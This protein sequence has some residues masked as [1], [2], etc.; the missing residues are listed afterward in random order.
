MTSERGGARAVLGDVG[1]RLARRT[2]R[3]VVRTESALQEHPVRWAAILAGVFAA[4]FF[5]L[6]TPTFD[7]NDD[8]GMMFIADGTFYGSPQPHLI[9]Q[10]PIVGIT[11]STLYRW[12]G[13]INW[14]SLWLYSLHA[15]ALVVLLALVLGDRR[16]R[17]L[18]RLAGLLA[19]WA[20]FT[21]SMW[22]ELQFTGVSITLGA[23]GVLWYA[24][25]AARDRI[26]YPVIAAAGVL[27]GLSGWVRWR[28]MQA[29]VVL[30]LPLAVIALRRIPW[31]RH[32]VFAGAALAVVLFGMV[33]QAIYYAGDDDWNE[34][35]EFNSVRGAIH[36]TER[37]RAAADPEVRA[38]LGWSE[39]DYWMFRDWFYLDEDRY[40]TETL[41]LLIDEVGTPPRGLRPVF[42]LMAGVV[43][44]T[45]LMVLGSLVVAAWAVSGRRGRLT[46]AAA[47]GWFVAVVVALSLFARLPG[48]VSLP[49]L[50]FL[51]ML[52]LIRPAAAFPEEYRPP[53]RWLGWGALGLVLAVAAAALG[54]GVHR[55][56]ADSG[57]HNRKSDSIYALLDELAAFDP[58]G[59]YVS[60]SD[61]LVISR[62]SP[63]VAEEVEPDLIALGWH[64]RTPMQDARFA[65]L[66]IDDLYEA[67]ARDERVYLPLAASETGQRW[68]LDYMAEHYGIEGFLRPAGA[69][70][71]SARLFVY[72]LV[73]AGYTVDDAAGV[74]RETRG[75][76]AVVEY[77]LRDDVAS[78][79]FRILQDGTDRLRGWV[80]DT[81]DPG[82]VHHIVVLHDDEIVAVEPTTYLRSNLAERFGADDDDRVGFIL[83]GLSEDVR[84]TARIFAVVG[85]AAYEVPRGSG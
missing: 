35:L 73:V 16:T 33:F 10:H 46:L 5:L 38:A 3:R 81:A 2:V 6:L 8:V 21:L 77:P 44:F 28:G 61:S 66:G 20:V 84:R 7:S 24:S 23:A 27:V 41:Q 52:Y 83:E 19:F 48:R 4:G 69:V 71:V 12:T 9:F 64:Q 42:D 34:F 60:W 51:G 47:T 59:V 85:D 55:A 56:V 14:Y 76:G 70:D 79:A 54:I 80:V 65:E 49:I 57:P 78:G 45:R 11:L 32:A 18:P 68:Y 40:S 26:P 17:L 13:A 58:D 53:P 62:V 31:R 43:P 36:S 15:G 25:V 37:V 29:V 39:A 82:P 50:A 63:E 72:D 74:L 75:D 67:I 1:R 30:A 22:M